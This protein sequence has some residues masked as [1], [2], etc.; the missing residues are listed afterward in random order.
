MLLSFFGK[1]LNS[2]MNNILITIC[3]RGGSK[4]LKGKNFKLL[5]EK[6]LIAYTI[7]QAKKWG[8]ARKIV[9]STDSKK[10]AKIAQEY[11]ALVPFIRPKKLA[12]DKSGKIPVIRHALKETEKIFGEKYDLIMDLDVTSP[13]RKLSDLDNSLNLFLKMKP[14]TLFSVVKAHRNPYFNMVEE[15]ANGLVVLSKPGGKYKRTQDAPKVYDM[16]ASIY[17]YDRKYLID[18]NNNSEQTDNSVAYVMD[19]I[20]RIDIDSEIDFKYIEFLIKESVI[21]I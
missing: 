16:N 6:P 15:R 12:T 3:A 2:K 11:Q 1:L 8:K 4:R 9:V 10:I 18:E 21:S 13:I 19:E 14:K 17:I 5:Q 20:S 7:E